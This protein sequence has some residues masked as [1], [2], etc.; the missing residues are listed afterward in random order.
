MYLLA[1]HKSKGL[2]WMSYWFIVNKIDLKGMGIKA[3]FHKEFLL[4][5]S[6]DDSVT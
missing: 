3:V 1:A 6:V 4:R 5:I 2:E